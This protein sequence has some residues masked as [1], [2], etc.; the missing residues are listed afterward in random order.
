MNTKLYVDN[1]TAAT[2]QNDL[3]NLFFAYGNVV[4]VHFAADHGRGQ[5]PG[6]GIVTMA[7]SEGARSA[8]A[9]LNGKT[10]GTFTLGV[11]EMQPNEQHTALARR[12]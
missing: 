9:A 8:I 10:V 3:R 5:T 12:H 2:T 6:F 1:L 7:T 11:R 4:E